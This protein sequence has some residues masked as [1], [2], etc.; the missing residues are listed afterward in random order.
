M[1]KAIV[2]DVIFTVFNRR[3]NVQYCILNYVASRLVVTMQGTLAEEVLIFCT[4]L[5]LEMLKELDAAALPF[6]SITELA[7]K[8]V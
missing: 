4:T 7:C 6:A 1:I 2:R 5:A 8:F 3:M